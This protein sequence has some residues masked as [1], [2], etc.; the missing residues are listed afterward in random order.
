MYKIVIQQTW[1]VTVTEITKIK[2]RGEKGKFTCTYMGTM[3]ASGH[4]IYELV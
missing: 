4:A 3:A 2:E 1:L